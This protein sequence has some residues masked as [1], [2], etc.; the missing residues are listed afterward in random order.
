MTQAEVRKMIRDEVAGL[1]RGR[2]DNALYG[3]AARHTRAAI[4]SRITGET[5]RPSDGRASWGSFVRLVTN[6]VG[7]TVW[8]CPADQYAKIQQAIEAV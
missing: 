1:N 8:T 5:I 4:A 7:V 6:A 2:W 3:P